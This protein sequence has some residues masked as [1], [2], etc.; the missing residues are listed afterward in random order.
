[1]TTNTSQ[2][3]LAAPQPFT[4]VIPEW[5]VQV[6][7]DGRTI[8]ARGTIEQAVAA[9]RAVNP[10]FDESFNITSGLPENTSVLDKRTVFDENTSTFTCQNSLPLTSI[11]AINDG[12][13]YLKGVK[14][15]PH[16]VGG[17]NVCSRVSCSYHAAIW[18]CNNVSLTKSHFIYLHIFQSC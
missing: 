11:E 3:V 13:K 12:I 2:P 17:S 14:G 4:E 1:M 8:T 6:H 5:E 9:A 18:W 10:D 15:R 7:P 16:L